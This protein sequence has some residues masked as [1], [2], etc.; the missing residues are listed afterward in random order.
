MRGSWSAGAWR[1]G[2]VGLLAVGL[3]GAL[4]EP[5]PRAYTQDQ[6]TAGGQVYAASCANCHGARGEGAGPDGPDAPL[7]V[8]PRGLTGFRDA[9]E[10]Y[11]FNRDSM[12]QDVP[13]SLPD[14]Q[15]WDVT[16]W[17]LAQNGIALPGGALGPGNAA[18]VSLR[19]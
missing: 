10:L 12:P 17:L 14:Q 18:G 19:R 7:V 9:Q 6:V 2:L 5:A 1:A 16:A 4:A 8:G 13:N 11:E 3:W 15:Y